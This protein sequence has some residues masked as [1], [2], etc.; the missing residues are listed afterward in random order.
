[1]ILPNDQCSLTAFL[2]LGFIG[3]GILSVVSI[4]GLAVWLPIEIERNGEVIK[5]RNSLYF[6][7]PVCS[8]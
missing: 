3:A 6:A 2:T 4:V 5:E 1:M 7:P 8:Y